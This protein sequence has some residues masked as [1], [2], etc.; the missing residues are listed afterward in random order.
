[1]EQDTTAVNT[2]ENFRTEVNPSDH[3][4]KRCANGENA[5]HPGKRQKLLVPSESFANVLR[6][7]QSL[8]NA[9]K[10]WTRPVIPPSISDIVFQCTDIVSG[11][12]GS[13]IMLFGTTQEENS[14][15]VR[16]KDY[17]PCFYF[18]AP[19][20]LIDSDLQP[21]ADYL[22][23]LLAEDEEIKT[24]SIVQKR[25]S[26][27]GKEIPYLKFTVNCKAA[28]MKTV[29]ILENGHCSYKDLFNSPDNAVQHDIDLRCSFISDT[30]VTICPLGRVQKTNNVVI[31]L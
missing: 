27:R 6:D 12:N 8:D 5:E 25:T 19:I 4:K 17:M 23:R 30:S 21:L 22:N 9:D 1:M 2:S 24:I 16:I 29:G 10:T 11:S 18:P 15:L 20:G 14:V 28:S 13:G 7:M 31:Q 26:A 3:P